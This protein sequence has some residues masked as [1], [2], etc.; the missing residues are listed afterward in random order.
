MPPGADPVTARVGF[1]VQQD[2]S[3]TL[4]VERGVRYTRSADARVARWFSEGQLDF[5]TFQELRQW[6]QTDLKGCY[7]SPPEASAPA[8]RHGEHRRMIA[9]RELTDLQAVTDQL[10]ANAQAV[11]LDEDG[12]FQQ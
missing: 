5:V 2:G 3:A 8:G 10:P 4:F 9:A 7:V 11:H 1:E 12:L 6:I